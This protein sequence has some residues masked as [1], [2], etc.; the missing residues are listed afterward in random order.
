MGVPS[1]N[2]APMLGAHQAASFPP[3]GQTPRLLIVSWVPPMVVIHAKVLQLCTA[4]LTAA[5]REAAAM[6][7]V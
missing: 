6:R 5:L 3:S 1:I 7:P 2:L 4:L